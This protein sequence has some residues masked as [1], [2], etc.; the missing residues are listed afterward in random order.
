MQWNPPVELTA[1]EV[2]LC[3]RLQKQRRFYRFLRL[4]RHRLFDAAFQ[5]ELAQMYSATPRGTPPVPPARLAMIVLLQAYAR[6]SDFDAVQNTEMDARWQLV[7]DCLDADKAL[8]GESTLVDFR[9]RLVTSGLYEALLRRTVDLAKETRDFGYKQVAGLRIAL[10]SSPL[11]G[12]GRVEDTINLLGHALRILVHAIAALVVLTPSEVIAG[13]RLTVVA[14]AS[15][16]AGLDQAWGGDDATQQALQTLHEEV[17]RLTAW[18]ATQRL[19]GLSTHAVEAARAQ[20]AHLTAQNVA[21]D[22]QG[23]LALIDGVAPD[24]QIS[25]SDPEMRHGRK[26]AT[27]KING[28]KQYVALDIDT[29]LTLAAGVLPANVPEAQGA[30]KLRPALDTHGPVQQ[31]L[32]DCAFTSSQLAADV[33]ARPD[34]D[35]VCRAV[36]VQNQGLYT[37]QDFTID[38]AARTVRCPAGNLVVIQGD[39]VHFADATCATCPQRAACQKPAAQHGRTI[40]IA[41]DEVALQA[42]IARQKTPEGRAQLRQRTAVEHTLAHHC[43]RQG[44]RARYRGV[45]MNDFDA[46]RTAAVGNLLVIDRRVR[47]ATEAPQRLAA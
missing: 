1:R 24:R 15:T 11:E 40:T 4:H 39:T 25:L 12:A 2:K 13:A 14:A 33:A 42:R 19:G 35:V 7:L 43:G 47:D 31:L 6:T 10:D 8:I 27:K 29:S 5:A 17:Q 9:T 36:R 21:P 38:V 26:S 41:P 34:G 45:R 46:C 16:K 22:A 32:I 28:Y 3:G 44:P 20:L 18:V 37:K 30:D 23:R